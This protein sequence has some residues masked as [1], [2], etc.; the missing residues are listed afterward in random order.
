MRP[1]HRSCFERVN[2]GSQIR[3]AR[4]PLCRK[5]RVTKRSRSLFPVSFFQPERP[6]L[7]GHRPVL[8]AAL[9]EASVH[10]EDHALSGECSQVFK[11]ELSKPSWDVPAMLMLKTDKHRRATLPD[12]VQPES[13][14]ALENGGPGRFVMT[15]IGKPTRKPLQAARGLPKAVWKKFDLE[16]PSEDPENWGA[17]E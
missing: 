5:V 10:E 9:P 3:S 6:V 7:Y 8:R 12:E 4:Q 13:L 15:I 17:G 2:S 11:L 14:V 16:G 1:A